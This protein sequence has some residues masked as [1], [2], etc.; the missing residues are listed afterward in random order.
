M[1]I[2]DKFM[3]LNRLKRWRIRFTSLRLIKV[4]VI[5][6]S[7]SPSLSKKWINKNLH[8]Y[9]MP[10]ARFWETWKMKK[11]NLWI[12]KSLSYPKTMT[13]LWFKYKRTAQSGLT[14]LSL[15]K[16]SN[17]NMRLIK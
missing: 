1:K 8:K 6:K 17:F 4:R 9:K 11:K 10:E 2:Q 14:D 15:L 13:L 16:L 5:S 12:L 3:D 7:Q